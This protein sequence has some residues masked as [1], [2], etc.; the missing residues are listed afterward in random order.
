MSDL[1]LTKPVR[2]KDTKQRF[3]V[4]LGAEKQNGFLIGIVNHKRDERD[5]W[6]SAAAYPADLENIPE[7]IV[8]QVYVGLDDGGNFSWGRGIDANVLLKLTRTE[9]GKTH[10]EVVDG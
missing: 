3:Y 10:A 4:A 1:D 9:D 6:A 5:E 2:R 8:R 7:P